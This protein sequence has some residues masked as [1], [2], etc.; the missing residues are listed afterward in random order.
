MKLLSKYKSNSDFGVVLLTSNSVIKE[1]YDNDTPFSR[2]CEKNMSLIA[3]EYP[4]AKRYGFWVVRGTYSTSDCAINI[5]DTKNKET[6]VGFGGG[7]SGVADLE[8]NGS[9]YTDSNDSGW[10]R[11]HDEVQNLSPLQKS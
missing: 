7:S 4:D 9:W 6:V 5:W 2:W 1:Y 10:S 3:K 11:W 8:A